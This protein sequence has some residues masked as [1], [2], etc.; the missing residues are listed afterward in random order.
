[1]IC[2]VIRVYRWVYGACLFSYGGAGQPFSW[3][4][5]EAGFH[6]DPHKCW[7]CPDRPSTA[8]APP[9]ATSASSV[10]TSR[11]LMETSDPLGSSSSGTGFEMNSKN[12]D[13]EVAF[14][15]GGKVTNL[16]A[17]SVFIGQMLSKDVLFACG[18]AGQTGINIFL[19][20]NLLAA[21]WLLHLGLGLLSTMLQHGFLFYVPTAGSWGN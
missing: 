9:P 6:F 18:L 21:F 3:T 4:T 10:A 7:G 2:C 13:C 15:L 1:M 19:A 16:F 14:V 17:T 11:K 12:Q 5:P 20:L 8:G